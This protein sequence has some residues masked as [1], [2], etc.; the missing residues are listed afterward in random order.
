MAEGDHLLLRGDAEAA[1]AFAAEMHLA[2]REDAA[3][4][5]ARKPCSTAARASPKS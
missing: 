4:G 1:A 3:A 2:L 5:E